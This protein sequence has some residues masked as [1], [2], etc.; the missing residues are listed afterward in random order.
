LATPRVSSDWFSP[1]LKALIQQVT[2]A[3]VTVAAQEVAR[4]GTGLVILLGV[5][6]ADTDADPQYLVDKIANLRIFPDDR[7]HFNHS[8]LETGAEL[9]VVSQ[10]TLCAD[11][12]KGRRP[13]FSDA[14]P[15]AEAERLYQR[16]VDLFRETGLTVA[17]GVFQEHMQVSL[18][19]D[20][21]VTIMLD[22]ADRHRSRRG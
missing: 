21:P 14:A 8:A 15:P 22:S 18:Q 20:G 12:R 17:T 11:T 4:I 19:N 5:A 13:D 10:F 3:S 16:A 9:L 2:R 7:S 1:L 6:K